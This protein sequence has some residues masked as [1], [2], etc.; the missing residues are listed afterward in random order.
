VGTFFSK[1]A[2][3]SPT[4]S[5]FIYI[6]NAKVF[7]NVHGWAA[8]PKKKKPKRVRNYPVNIYGDS[9]SMAY[10]MNNEGKLISKYFFPSTK[11]DCCSIKD[12]NIAVTLACP[13]C[14]HNDFSKVF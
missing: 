11:R 14:N 1:T 13:A 10:S 6:K 7:T 3:K 5:F 9:S 2:G 4:Y 12:D 8:S